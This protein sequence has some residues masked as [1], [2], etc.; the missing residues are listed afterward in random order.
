MLAGHHAQATPTIGVWASQFYI[1]LAR[2]V[3][4][5]SATRLRW[6]AIQMLT[7][8]LLLLCLQ[9]P[10]ILLASFHQSPRLGFLS[11]P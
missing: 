6:A 7:K 8:Q 4:A 5:A 11:K 3:T 10:D 1:W 9:C 2:P